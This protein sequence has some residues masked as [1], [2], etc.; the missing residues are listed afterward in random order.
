MALDPGVELV[1]TLE[2]GV[3]EPEGQR[4]LGAVVALPAASEGGTRSAC[5]GT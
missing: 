2:R 1:S 4:V 5:L 3:E